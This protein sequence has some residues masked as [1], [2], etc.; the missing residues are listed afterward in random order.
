MGFLE[1]NRGPK[2]FAKTT[3]H[4]TDKGERLAKKLEEVEGELEELKH[5]IE[6]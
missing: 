4:L 5:D 1:M 2:P 3:Y 6:Y